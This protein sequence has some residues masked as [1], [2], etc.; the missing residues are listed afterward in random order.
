MFLALAYFINHF[1]IILILINFLH[2]YFSFIDKPL[3]IHFLNSIILIIYP[4]LISLLFQYS[5]IF[6]PLHFFFSKSIN[7]ALLIF[8]FLFL[9]IFQAYLKYHLYLVFFY[10]LFLIPT[11]PIFK[12][13]PNMTY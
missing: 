4:V 12:A 5:F 2:K 6:I 1:Q 10:S 3:L 9:T 13:L 7:Y 8:I 11:K